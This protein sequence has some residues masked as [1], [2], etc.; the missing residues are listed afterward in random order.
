[1][2]WGKVRLTSFYEII[3][4]RNCLW[5]LQEVKLWDSKSWHGPA[6]KQKNDELLIG[7]PDSLAMR[8]RLD[9]Q[10]FLWKSWHSFTNYPLE[11]DMYQSSCVSGEKSWNCFREL[12]QKWWCILHHYVMTRPTEN[13]LTFWIH[14]NNICVV[15]IGLY[16][17]FLFCI[18]VEEK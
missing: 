1:M 17:S 14:G 11:V 13:F 16:F 8:S 3:F 9:S 15:V 12:F 5:H 7:L 10:Q 2:L 6:K 18:K 4:H